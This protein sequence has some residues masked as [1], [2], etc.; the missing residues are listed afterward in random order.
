MPRI[1]RGLLVALAAITVIAG[2]AVACG[3]DD[4]DSS[5]NTSQETIDA[6]N[7]RMQRNEMLFAVVHMR[8]LG[9]HAMDESLAEGTIESSFSGNTQTAVRLFA[10]TDWDPSLAADAEELRGHAV[11]L[12]QALRDEDV[13]AAAAAAKALHDGEHDFSNEVWAILAADL[14][15]DA[16]GVEAHDD[17]GETPAAGE[18]AEGGDHSDDETPAAGATEE[19]DDHSEDEGDEPESEATP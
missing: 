5:S 3:D 17:G 19:G 15:A 12:L 4:A 10:L 7:A 14:P 18:T 8:T 6:V 9:L 13:D 16:G 2:V 1:S 11:D